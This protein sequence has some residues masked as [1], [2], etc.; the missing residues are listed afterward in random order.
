[1]S[2]IDT[3]VEVPVKRGGFMESQSGIQRRN[4]KIFC[5]LVQANPG[6]RTAF[7]LVHPNSNFH[8]HYLIAPLVERGAAVFLVN[9]RYVANDV[10]LL[11][12]RA[13][14]DLGAAIRWLRERGFARIVL[15]G[16]SG[17]GSLAAMYQQQAERLSITDTPDGQ[18]IA[19]HPDDLPPADALA[20][21]CAHPGRAEQLLSKID[22]SVLDERTPEL[23]HPDLDLYGPANAPPYSRE[24]LGRYRAAQKAR[25]D[26]ITAWVLARL[27]QLEA[28]L[29]IEVADEP[30]LIHR[31]QADPRLLDLSLD[32]NDRKVGTIQGDPAHTNAAAN[33]LA[34]ICTLRSFLSQ[35]SPSHTR[36]NGPACLSQTRVPVLVVDH[37]AD[38]TTFPSHV[39]QWMNAAG[40]RGRLERLRGAPH[41]LDDKPELKGGLAGLLLDWSEAL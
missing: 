41:Y 25:L 37:T 10:M 40:S 26:R 30:F 27:R 18:P 32:A 16:N 8:S 11:M 15:I 20:F 22:P 13:I 1:M 35:W 19:L 23:R 21:S 34:R 28:S 12:E 17:G 3:F 29:P 2:V 38:Q 39:E 14:Q 5:R 4:P 7:V 31:T 9:T 36:A 6:A 24:W 33:G